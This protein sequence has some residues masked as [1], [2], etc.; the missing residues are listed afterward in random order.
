MTRKTYAPGYYP[1][2]PLADYYADP[3]KGDFGSLNSSGIPYIRNRSPLHFAIR[4]PVLVE[5]YGL[6]PAE[7]MKNAAMHCGNVVHRLALGKGAE[8][9]ILDFDN[10]RTKEAQT[11]KKE[12]EAAGRS[13]VL[14]KDFG[15]MQRQADA[16]RTHLNEMFF[17][18]AWLPEVAFVWE[19]QT[20]FGPVQCR[21][22]VDAYCPTLNHGVDL[23]ATTDASADGI[24]RNMPNKGYDLQ[25][26]WYS[27]G[28]CRV[29]EC[30]PQRFQFTTLF[31]ETKPPYGTQGFG[32][33]EAWRTSAWDECQI[34]LRLMAQCQQRDD[35]PGYSRNPRQ[36]MP[37]AWLISRRLERELEGVDLNDEPPSFE[38]EE[39]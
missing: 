7:D 15:D 21:A 4:S 37:P 10:F 39:A 34:A 6:T 18:E 29:T 13:C 17:G 19:E 35:F 8:Y 31:G 30:D 24:A 26:A 32:L 23:K 9:D 28:V 3:A 27:R 11:A 12:A 22:L 36:L 33:S 1:D 2:M 16:L 5:R 38:G 14:K 25:N 20:P